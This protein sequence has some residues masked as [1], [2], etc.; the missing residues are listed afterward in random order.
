[1]PPPPMPERGNTHSLG[2]IVL[3]FLGN[4]VAF[5]ATGADLQGNGGSPEFGL[6][7]YQVRFPG[8]A[9]TV[10]CMADL[11]AGDC[12]LSADIASP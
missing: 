10:L 8:P 12:V 9:G 3:D 2:I 4:I 5:E 1:M 7:L 11:I 6:N